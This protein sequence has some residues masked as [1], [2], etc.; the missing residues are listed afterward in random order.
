MNRSLKFN[1]SVNFAFAPIS[2]HKTNVPLV[3]GIHET[4]KWFESIVC[5]GFLTFCA[6]IFAFLFLN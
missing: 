6:G 3:D 2:K 5:F 1:S 4:W